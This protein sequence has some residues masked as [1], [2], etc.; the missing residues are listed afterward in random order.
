MKELLDSIKT[1]EITE[2][3]RNDFLTKNN[4]SHKQSFNKIDHSPSIVLKEI[5]FIKRTNLTNSHRNIVDDHIESLSSWK[6]NKFKKYLTIAGY[7]LTLG[8]LYIITL[9]DN[10]IILKLYCNR[11]NPEESNYI[12]ITDYDNK[13]YLVPLISEKLTN[14]NQIFRA[15]NRN[16]TKLLSISEN[17]RYINKN[18]KIEEKNN[19]LL[20][21]YFIFK[22]V[23]YIYHSDTF[24]FSSA[25]FNLN[26]YK[27]REILDLF[28]KANN[29]NSVLNEKKE[30][31]LQ[32]EEEESVYCPSLHE[33]NYLINKY[34]FNQIINESTKLYSI[35][36][37]QFFSG[38]NYFCIAFE[39]IWFFIGYKVYAIIIFLLNLIVLIK[40]TKDS[41]T[42][43]KRIYELDKD[44]TSQD[45]ANKNINSNNLN[46]S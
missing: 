39:L 15:G 3:E 37:K 45:N 10:T 33:Y 29:R 4:T 19:D 18:N 14:L 12:L 40:S 26:H 38:F 1:S 16:E 2:E 28:D 36:L 7:F 13:K 34:G 43:N 17:S 22:N 23:R 21:L 35:I 30:I 27:H 25:Y 20:N 8:I 46:I 42:L 32:E 31:S 9:Y 5:G 44:N 24:C 41:Y 11:A 6:I